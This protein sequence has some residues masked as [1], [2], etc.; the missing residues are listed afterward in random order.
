MTTTREDD[1]AALRAAMV[2]SLRAQ[3]VLHCERVAAAL[4]TVPRHEFAPGEPLRKAYD[5]H[6]TLVP[7]RAADGTELSV[8]SASHIQA[9]MLEQ[10]RIEPGM[11]VLEIGSS[12]YNAALIA[13]MVGP[14]G[15]V[16]TVDIDPIVIDRART[17]LAATGYERVNVVHADADAGVPAHAPYDRIIVTVGAWDIPPAWPDQLSDTGRIV[18]PLRFAGISR[19]IAFDRTGDFLTAADYRLGAFVAMQGDGQTSEKLVTITDD[20]GLYLDPQHTPSL[21]VPALREALHGPRIDLWADTEFDMPDEL[22]L[23]LLTN[24]GEQMVM[25][26]AAQQAIDDGLVEPPVRHGMPALV[27]GG[28]FAYRLKRDS[29][30]FGSKYEAGVR[31]HGPDAAAVGDEFLTLVRRWGGEYFRRN[32]A[33][34][35]Y[36]PTGAAGAVPAGWKTVK[37]HGT[38]T[39]T[40][41]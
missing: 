35:Q 19:L 13:E 21:D 33:V 41:P 20:I 12:G 34:I 17:C 31:A 18:L 36:H 28:S 23:F 3:D 22:A 39:V 37:R 9:I 16:T 30:D 15:Q 6:T 26:H 2:A 27:R 14:S 40:W 24:G 25:L 5:T 7:V 4:A 1:P 32:A 10:A 8:V 29:A 38:L 11:R